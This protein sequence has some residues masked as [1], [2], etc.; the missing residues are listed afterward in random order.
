M[1][2]ESL[3]PNGDDAGWTTGGWDDI[4]ELVSAANDSDFIQTATDGEGEVIDLDLVDSALA[5]A[6]TITSVEVNLRAIRDTAGVGGFLTVALLIGGASQGN[7]VTTALTESFADY[8]LLNN[9]GWDSDWT[10]AE[11]DGMQIRVT[12]S[13]SGKAVPVQMS[14][15]A[16]DVLITYTPASAGPDPAVFGHHQAHIVLN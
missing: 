5:D 10:A 2:E 11:L 1:A 14:V 13:Q 9:V 3:L 6:D 12:A 15:S 16:L 8:L 4:N 7:A